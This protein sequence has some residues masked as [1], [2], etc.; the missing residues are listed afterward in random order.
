VLDAVADDAEAAG[1]CSSA[2][3]ER[4]TAMNPELPM[5]GDMD[6]DTD[7]LGSALDFHL[8]PLMPKHTL[9]LI[10]VL[11]D[12]LLP[13]RARD[14]L[15]ADARGRFLAASSLAGQ[16]CRAY[17]PHGVL[18]YPAAG[19]YR[20][21]LRC[22][23]YQPGSDAP[24]EIGFARFQLSLPEPPAHAWNRM[25]F[26]R[27]L[28]WLGLALARA[29]RSVGAAEMRN[30]VSAVSAV[31]HTGPSDIPSLRQVVTERVEHELGWLV[32]VVMARFGLVTHQ[33]LMEFLSELAWADDSIDERELEVLQEV[34]THLGLSKKEWRAVVKQHRLHC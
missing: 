28:V 9:A 16:R 4:I 26:V 29:D 23:Q 20:V 2:L 10:D 14:P 13:L 21:R 8:V 11:D 17:V 27:P 6:I 7:D 19:W 3:I 34:A 33:H 18:E 32:D 12:E 31:L 15:F 5:A 30:L 1:I 25:D 22:V 24:R